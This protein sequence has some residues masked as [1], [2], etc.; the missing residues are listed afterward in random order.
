MRKSALL[1][2]VQLL[3]HDPDLSGDGALVWCLFVVPTL[4]PV[5]HFPHQLG[6][7]GRHAMLVDA[8]HE[9]GVE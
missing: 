5:T 2:P 1:G 6:L 7:S 9:H 4:K 3:P 8:A